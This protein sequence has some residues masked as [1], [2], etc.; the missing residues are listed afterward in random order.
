[1]ATLTP[2]VREAAEI[3]MKEINAAYGELKRRGG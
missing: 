3:R 1:V 2:E